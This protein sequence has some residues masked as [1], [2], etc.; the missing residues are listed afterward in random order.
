MKLFKLSLIVSLLSIFAISCSENSTD[1]S[2]DDPRDEITGIYQGTLTNKLNIDKEYPAEVHISEVSDE[3]IEMYLFC[4]IM[5]TT[6]VFDVYRN[7][8]SL[9]VCLTGDDFEHHYGHHGDE[10][11]HMMGDGHMWDW[12]HHLD[13]DHR[14]GEEHYGGFH[15]EDHTFR[16]EFFNPVHERMEYVFEGQMV[17]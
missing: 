5:D 6:I 7:D 10:G 3:S 14:P 13:E 1:A 15:M 16:Y 8:D 17:E 4:E 12:Q 9:M 11:H 2:V